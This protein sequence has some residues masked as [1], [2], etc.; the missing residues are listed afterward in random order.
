MCVNVHLSPAGGVRYTI[1]I[2]Q[3]NEAVRCPAGLTRAERE[4]VCLAEQKTKHLAGELHSVVQLSSQSQFSLACQVHSE[5]DGDT[6]VSG[7]EGVRTL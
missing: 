5:V 2:A 1:L 3:G 6:T 4:H 7:S